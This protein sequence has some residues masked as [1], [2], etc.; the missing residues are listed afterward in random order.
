M[1]D[2]SVRGGRRM[3][4]IE[5]N[6]DNCVLQE[7]DLRNVDLAFN[8]FVS[9]VS[10]DLKSCF[11]ELSQKIIKLNDLVKQAKEQDE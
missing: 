11:L 1:R 8:Y 9:K 4:E 10:E 3:S 7:G 6:E 5:I 2:R